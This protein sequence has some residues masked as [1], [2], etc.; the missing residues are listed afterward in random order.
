MPKES[1]TSILSLVEKQ[2]PPTKNRNSARLDS[3]N[4]PV[5]AQAVMN[6]TPPI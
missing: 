4:A 5:A 2:M 3:I 6:K 1:T